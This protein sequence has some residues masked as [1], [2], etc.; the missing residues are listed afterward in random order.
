MAETRKNRTQSAWTLLCLLAALS[1]F[2][3]AAAVAAPRAIAKPPTPVFI[4][5]NPIGAVVIVDGKTLPERTP[6]LLRTLAAGKH[7]VQIARNG[8]LPFHGTLDVTGTKPVVLRAVLNETSFVPALGP[9]EKVVLDGKRVDL[10]TERYRLPAGQYRIG[11][12]DGTVTIDPIFPSQQVMNVVDIMTGGLAVASLIVLGDTILNGLTSSGSNNSGG[13]NNLGG[14]I[15]VWSL[16]GMSAL[17]DALLH[18]QKL[19]F[20]KDSA[21]IP[22]KRPPVDAE[23]TFNKAQDLLASGSLNGAAELYVEILRHDPESVYY[24]RALYQLAKIHAIEGDNLLA[25]A[26]LNIIL[27][28]YPLPDLY[29]KTCKSLADISYRE[30]DYRRAVSYLDRMVF[31]DPLFPR[32]QIEAYRASI[33]KKISQGGTGS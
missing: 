3:P 4:T 6:L 1:I 33:E 12:T 21:P 2:L 24:P 5:S 11:R 22:I 16:T 30:Q 29:D 26:E 31:Y 25:T 20:L 13:G 10:A 19:K 8:Y 18:I 23:E 27:G 28:K 14:P 32:G 17:T 15:A 9:H 7:R